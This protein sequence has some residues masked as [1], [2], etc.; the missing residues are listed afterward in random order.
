MIYIR[1][2]RAH[3]RLA[4]G[5][6]VRDLFRPAKLA[7]CFADPQIIVPDALSHVVAGQN[8]VSKTLTGSVLETILGTIAFPT[9]NF[10]GANGLI[11][12]TSLWTVANN[13]NAKTVRIKFSGPAGT[14]LNN[15]QNF[16][17]TTSFKIVNHIL[18]QGPQAQLAWTDFITAAGTVGLFVAVP[19]VDTTLP[20][21]SIVITGQL[22]NAGDAL[23][24]Q[25]YITELFRF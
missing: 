12:V 25:G 17:N 7:G 1:P 3:A 21:T 8:G 14:D 19:A 2:R 11:R 13:A 15:A 9:P 23:I 22:A 4:S 6:I 16:A 5:I 10:L 20:N 18:A 24:L